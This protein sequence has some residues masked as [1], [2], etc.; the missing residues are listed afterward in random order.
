MAQPTPKTRL[1][2]VVAALRLLRVLRADENQP[3][4]ED[5]ALV[6]AAYTGLYAELQ[7]VGVAYWPED[8][9]PVLVIRPLARMLAAECSGEF[10]KSYQS[11]DAF[12]RLCAAAAKPWSGD[13]I[14]GEYL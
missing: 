13:N 14:Q 5:T 8:E 3:T 10:G 9:V 7:N 2:L 6:D 12:D 1:D 4:A 11:E